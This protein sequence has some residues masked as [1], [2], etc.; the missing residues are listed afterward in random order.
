MNIYYF[1]SEG[2]CE[3]RLRALDIF[4]LEE[5][6]MYIQ[7]TNHPLPTDSLQGSN[8]MQ[9][10]LLVPS[11]ISSKQEMRSSYRTREI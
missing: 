5:L 9:M 3:E 4:N 10:N 7:S 1:D 2:F 6:N 11:F 8:R